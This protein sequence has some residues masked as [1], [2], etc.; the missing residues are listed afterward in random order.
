METGLSPHQKKTLGKR[1]MD[2]RLAAGHPN[3]VEA[4]RQFGFNINTFKG[5]EYGHR[6]FDS[7]EAARYAS[8]FGVTPEHLTDT[9]GIP[10]SAVPARQRQPAPVPEAQRTTPHHTAPSRHVDAHHTAPTGAVSSQPAP[11]GAHQGSVVRTS[12]TNDGAGRHE[13]PVTGASGFGVWLSAAG[14]PLH[15]AARIP[16]VPDHPPELQYARQAVGDS[17]SGLYRD[18]DYIIF[19][20]HAGGRTAPGHHD[21]LRRKGAL[22]ESSVWV[23]TGGRR[24]T[25]DSVTSAEAPE[26]FDIDPEDTSVVIEGIAIAVYRPIKAKA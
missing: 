7:A 11:V 1:L 4:C 21:V 5:H 24:M 10:A 18:G 9:R 16:A 22:A 3:R 17:R 8:A 14:T 20:R 25:S 23:L 15:R 26:E 2:A 13:V 19:L 6:S 12:R